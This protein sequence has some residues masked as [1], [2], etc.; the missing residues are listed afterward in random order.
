[1][2]AGPQALVFLYTNINCFC[3]FYQKYKL[4]M[5]YVDFTPNPPRRSGARGGLDSGDI[6]RGK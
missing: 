6:S 3:L 5:K 1:M 2:T 4:G